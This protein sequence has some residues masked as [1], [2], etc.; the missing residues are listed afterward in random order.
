LACLADN[1]FLLLQLKTTNKFISNLKQ[2]YSTKT[3]IG[4]CPTFGLLMATDVSDLL[5]SCI[6]NLF[7]NLTKIE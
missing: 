4:C 7:K 5:E 6:F 2:K 1:I 3:E